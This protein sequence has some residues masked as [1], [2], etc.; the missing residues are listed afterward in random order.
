MP[1]KSTIPAAIILSVLVPFAA[2]SV[3]A[4][5]L[6]LRSGVTVHGTL[7][8][9]DSRELRFLTEEGLIRNYQIGN[10]SSVVFAPSGETAA[11]EAAAPEI[12]SPRIR[13][14]E[15]NIST[16]ATPEDFVVPGGTILTVRM[17]DAIDSDE[18]EP[19]EIFHASLANDL[20]VDNNLL[21]ARGADATV[22]LVAVEQAGKFRGR[23]EVSMV[24]RDVTINGKIYPVETGFASVAG[25]SRGKESAKVIGGTTA[26]GAIIGAI[27][28]GGKGAAIGAASGA[29]A[30]AAIQVIRGSEV[31]VP[32]ESILD[33][34][35]A[36]PV[37]ITR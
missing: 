30:G 37:R 1:I 28:G 4:D 31:K 26:V 29:G 12:Q 8:G 6:R 3:H 9:A 21:A 14:S 24:L 35:L 10:V 33:F 32:S 7:L 23:E 17:I 36:E 27:T 11:A 18:N 16:D 2:I 34:T 25:G 22:K 19:G 13:S 15:G 20:I 5:S